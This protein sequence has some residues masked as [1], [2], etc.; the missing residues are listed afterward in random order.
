MQPS[1]EIAPV[2]P[3]EHGREIVDR[4]ARAGLDAASAARRSRAT[5]RRVRGETV[6]LAIGAEHF[7]RRAAA[8]DARQQNRRGGL[9]DRQRRAA[10]RVGEAHVGG[11]FA[12]ADGVHQIGVG[13]K[14]HDKSRRA[15]LA[16]QARI[17]ALKDRGAAGNGSARGRRRASLRF[18]THRR[19]RDSPCRRRRRLDGVVGGVD[20]VVEIVLVGRRR[21]G[22]WRRAL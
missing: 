11:L 1:A 10:Q 8:I 22:L 5:R 16:T 21:P 9:E 7:A 12:H 13:I 19:R 2:E 17:E 20:G 15:A 14:L 4:A 18:A 3:R 6:K